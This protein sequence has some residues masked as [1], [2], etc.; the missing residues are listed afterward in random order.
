MTLKRFL[1]TLTALTLAA[2]L[3]VTIIPCRSIR[4]RSGSSPWATAFPTTAPSI[5]LAC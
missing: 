2:L 3:H 4:I 1:L 5:S